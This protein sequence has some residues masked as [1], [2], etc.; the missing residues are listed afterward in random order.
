MRALPIA[1]SIKDGE[2]GFKSLGHVVGVEDG[3][4]G[5]L[6]R[7]GGREGGREGGIE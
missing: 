7:G 1:A 2:V 4:L 3:D 5:G 6:G